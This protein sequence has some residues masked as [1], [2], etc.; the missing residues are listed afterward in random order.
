MPWSCC[1]LHSTHLL[2]QLWQ[3]LPQ[4][5]QGVPCKLSPPLQMAAYRAAGVG[6]ACSTR[7]RC[8]LNP[9]SLTA[10]SR[11]VCTSIHQE[12]TIYNSF[13]H[14][15]ILL[16][17]LTPLSFGEREWLQIYQRRKLDFRSKAAIPKCICIYIS[18]HTGEEGEWKDEGG[19]LLLFASNLL[20][21]YFLYFSFSFH[22]KRNYGR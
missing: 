12:V 16:L 18:R 15:L 21:S 20:S 9:S 11:L 19:L 8:C 13:F 2:W 17:L 5:G 22:S 1:Q 14:V 4:P 3:T 7:E 6:S 10:Q